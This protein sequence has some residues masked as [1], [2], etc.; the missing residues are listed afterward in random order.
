MIPLTRAIPECI[1]GGWFTT[2]RYTST[3]CNQLRRPAADLHL[4][5][6]S[7]LDSLECVAQFAVTFAS[8]TRLIAT[9]SVRLNLR[10]LRFHLSLNLG[11]IQQ[12]RR[13]CRFPAGHHT[14]GT[15]NNSYALDRCMVSALRS[16]VGWASAR[17]NERTNHTYQSEHPS[18]ACHASIIYTIKTVRGPESRSDRPRYCVMLQYDTVY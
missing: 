1:R 11:V 2:M 5:V 10:A 7:E 12:S 4:F 14:Y 17:N 6:E 3:L 18:T 16:R 13:V 8:I 9:V 15:T